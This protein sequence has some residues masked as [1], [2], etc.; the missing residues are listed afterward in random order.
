METTLKKSKTLN[1]LF[2]EDLPTDVEISERELSKAGLAFVSL[3]VETEDGL[4][5]ALH[6][7]KPDI[8]VSDYSMPSF[9]GMSA[10][11]MVLEFDPYLPFIILTGSM[12]ED[13]AVSCMKAGASDYVI[14]E[15]IA[16][17]PYAMREALELKKN[18]KRL[19]AQEEQLRRS[20][21]RY[22]SIFENSNAIMLVIDP[23]TGLIADAN[24]AAIAYYGWPRAELIG[25]KIGEIN[26]LPPERLNEQVRMAVGLEKSHFLFRHRHADGTVTDVESHS[27]PITMDDKTYLFSIIHDIS[28]RVSAQ[29]E[30]DELSGRLTHYLATSPT[31]TYA[32]HLTEGDI[33]MEWMSE[34]VAGILGY[35][36]KEAL[37]PGW[38][39]NNVA[40]EDREGALHG[41]AELARLESYAQEYRFLRKNRSTVWLRDEMRIVHAGTGDTANDGRDE[42]VGTLTDISG[43]KQSEA[44]TALK[45][46]ALEAAGNAIV[47]T[48]RDGTIE[49]A[50]T[51]FQSLTGYTVKEAVGRN[52]RDLVKS[53]S[54]D[55]A[56]YRQLWDTIL[57]GKT[58][59]GEL[60]NKRKTGELYDEEMLIT[61][62]TDASGRIEH[63]IAVKNEIT[64][65]KRS[66]KLL[67]SSLREKEIL[68]REV[69]HRVKNNMQIVSSLLNLSCENIGDSESCRII[70]EL[71][72][73]IDAMAIVH[74]QFY[75]ADDLA[76]IDFS[77]F[78]PELVSSIIEDT[79]ALPGNPEIRYQLEPVFLNLEYA[80]PVGLIVSELVANALKYSTTGQDSHGFLA[81]SLRPVAGSA[82]ELEIRDNGPGFPEGF[83]TAAATTLGMR[84]IQ[85][86]TEQ[87]KGNIRIRNDAGAVVTLRFNPPA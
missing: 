70:A 81:L 3:R 6:S 26:T 74:E 27:G 39:F 24:Q 65:R 82:V 23:D 12:N 30:R 72:R 38:W 48:D 9:D 8:V 57:S 58:W 41:I 35:S 43:R 19:D 33:H 53:G 34:N 60:V 59:Q 54:Q 64:E 2:I 67:E 62:V 87:L 45:S 18:E 15:H 49:W 52:P 1:V 13:I 42:I 76:R 40:S 20:E 83:D 31:I 84:L 51:A 11:V 32:F 50:N 36:V 85:I 47:I 21:S 16:R 73:R 25:K 4:K 71:H 5:K 66:R 56:M 68:L 44:E 7:F 69:H 10:L 77:V 75:Q 46:S 61:P 28:L 14:K 78:L 37:A 79:E 22:R 80:I 17:L 86:L 63:F 55:P 29:R